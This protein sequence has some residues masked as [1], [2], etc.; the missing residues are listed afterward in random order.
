MTMRATPTVSVRFRIRDPLGLHV[1]PCAELASEM[2]RF[3]C[4]AEVLSGTRRADPRSILELFGLAAGL[5]TELEFRATGEDAAEC[6]AAVTALL[7]S[8]AAVE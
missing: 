1:R 7:R 5:G 2:Q 6:V 4:H 8:S 3:R